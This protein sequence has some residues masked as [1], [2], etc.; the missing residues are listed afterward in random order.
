[1]PLTVDSPQA[2]HGVF[3]VIVCGIIDGDGGGI[4]LVGIQSVVTTTAT[5]F[6]LQL[7]PSTMIGFIVCAGSLERAQQLGHQN[8]YMISIAVAPEDS[9]VGRTIRP[10]T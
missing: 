3:E 4:S 5:R 10:G 8:E 2:I 7:H 1:M 6:F 9:K